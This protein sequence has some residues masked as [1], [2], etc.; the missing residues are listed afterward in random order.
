MARHSKK[1]RE[2]LAEVA[3]LDEHVTDEDTCSISLFAPTGPRSGPPFR[4]VAV[5]PDLS[6]RLRDTTLASLK[7]ATEAALSDPDGVGPYAFDALPDHHISYLN[8][9]EADFVGEWLDAIPAALEQPVF[10]GDQGY[11]KKIKHYT[12]KFSIADNKTFVRFRARTPA[13]AFKKGR[14]HAIFEANRF[15]HVAPNILEFDDVS[16]LLLFEG[17]LFVLNA[18]GFDRVV[19]CAAKIKEIATGYMNDV[20]QQIEVANADEVVAKL[21]ED[22]AFSKKVLSMERLNITAQITGADLA[23]VI[24]DFGVDIGYKLEGDRIKLML[25]PDDRS[26]M[27]R[28][29][30][31]LSLDHVE[32]AATRE[33][34]VTHGAKRPVG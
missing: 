3:A 10:D 7:K 23:K 5:T 1:A 34:F 26:Q 20:M 22:G 30:R 24:D 14:I 25:N 15:T 16:D 32:A 11:L 33:K 13:M 28:F 27:W 17:F 18:T 21:S 4:T 6:Y 29:L 19:D 12:L 31:L 9:D 8:V 2:L